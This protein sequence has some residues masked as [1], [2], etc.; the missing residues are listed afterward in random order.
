MSRSVTLGGNGLLPLFIAWSFLVFVG[1]VLIAGRTLGEQRRR[2]ESIVAAEAAFDDDVHT[3]GERVGRDA[4]IDDVVRLRAVG[5]PKRDLP[6]AGIAHDRPVHD[7]RANLDA[8]LVESG[9]GFCFS[10]KLARS[11][12]IDSGVADG[13]RG[14]IAGS[15]NHEDAANDELRAWLHDLN[16]RG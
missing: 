5:H 2:P 14:E 4:A 3:V 7:P 1:S 10:G 6:A 15:P 9:V 11:Q 8:R 16:I 13:A 12:V